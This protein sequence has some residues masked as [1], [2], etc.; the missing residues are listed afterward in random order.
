MKSQKRGSRT[1][2]VLV[3]EDNFPYREGI[4]RLLEALGLACVAVED[5]LD[6]VALLEDASEPFDLVV[7]DFRM[8]RGSGWRVVDAARAYRGASFPV[9]MQTGE[10]QYPDVYLKA[11]ELAVPLLAKADIYSLLVPLVSEALRLGHSTVGQMSSGEYEE[12]WR[13]S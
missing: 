9:I 3:A 10:A 12:S 7:T 2:R 13:P 6:A 11:E 4:V 1:Y 5:G 8:P